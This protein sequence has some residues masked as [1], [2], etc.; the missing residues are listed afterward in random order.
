MAGQS[1]TKAEKA[2][3]APEDLEAVVRE[4]L[5][6]APG[7]RN[8]QIKKALPKP[9]QAFAK[10]ALAVAQRLATEGKVS[11]FSA[12]RGEAFFERDPLARL[13]E[14]ATQQL[15]RTPLAK[16]A[17]KELLLTHAPGHEVA[18][19]PWFKRALANGLLHEYTEPKSK[20]R[21]GTEPDVRGSLG[22]VLTA[23][24]KVLPKTDARG[25]SR[26]SV[27]EV[28]LAELGISLEV[29]RDPRKE[30]RPALAPREDFWAALQ[31]V[32]AANPRQALLSIREV[33]AHSALDKDQFDRLALDLMREG[34]VSLHHHDHAASLP[35]PERGQ[36]V[37]DASGNHY[38][39]IA[40]RIGS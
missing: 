1:R 6:T 16:D 28:L 8:T 35:D 22:P 40:P 3:V 37:V 19:E 20:K 4:A 17:L 9:Y 39:G 32:A 31:A 18:F 30:S 33:R 10:E 14:L 5:R 7:T 12:G 26:R 15:G 2:R 27:A 29:P 21:F 24:R 11:R 25:I 34:K 36:L 13:D 38:I 23:L